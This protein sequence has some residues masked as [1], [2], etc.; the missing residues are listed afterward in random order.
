MANTINQGTAGFLPYYAATGT[1]LSPISGMAWDNTNKVLTVSG[2]NLTKTSYNA[3]YGFSGFSFQ[4]FHAT[5]EVNSFNFVRGRGNNT[6]KA[7][8]LNTDH[9]ANIVAAGWGGTAPVA[10]GYIRAIVNGTPGTTSMPTEWVFGTHNGTALADRAKITKDGQFNVNSISNFSGNDLTLAPSGKVVLGAI[11]KVNIS[12]GTNGQALTTDGAGN[13]SWATITGATGPQGPAGPK[14]DTG[15]TGATGATGPQ[16]PKG[17]TGAT[18]PQGPAGPAGGLT[19]PITVTL[20]TTKGNLTP[21]YNIDGDSDADL[22]DGIQYLK[23]MTGDATG[24]SLSSV[25]WIKGDWGTDGKAHAVIAVAEGNAINAMNSIVGLPADVN[26]GDT[27]FIG[28]VTAQNRTDIGLA[29]GGNQVAIMAYDADA[30]KNLTLTTSTDGLGMWTLTGDMLVDGALDASSVSAGAYIQTKNYASTA[31]RD[32]AIPTPSAG[33]IVAVAGAF[34]VYTG[35][36]W[37]TVGATGPAGAPGGAIGNWTIYVS[38]SSS[39]TVQTPTAAGE[40]RANGT[41]APSSMT[42]LKAKTINL[43]GSANILGLANALN[44]KTGRVRIQVAGST[45]YSYF[46]CSIA[47]DNGAQGGVLT[48]GLTH[49][50][51]TSGNWSGSW[52]NQTVTLSFEGV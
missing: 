34:Q 25:K 7:V 16:G 40:I 30:D 31:A 36:A 23:W 24:P 8:P 46:S 41:G 10:G 1:D 48:L 33:M 5:K 39:T 50:Y 6:T 19:N 42:T 12:G 35:S 45:G 22:A 21:D 3:G 32:T 4:Q 47:S 15:A 43:D 28:N 44:T 17:D 20:E 27:M 11:S 52:A 26:I 49:L 9:L 18:G 14:G 51:S 38:G 37:S 29:I 13:L 2:V